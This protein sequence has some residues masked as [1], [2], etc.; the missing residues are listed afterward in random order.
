MK[1]IY[2]I[3]DQETIIQQ[4]GVQVLDTLNGN[5]QYLDRVREGMRQCVSSGFCGY[6]LNSLNKDIAAKTGTAEVGMASEQLTNSL[7][8]G[9]AP[10]DNPK[11]AFVCVAPNSY[12]GVTQANITQEIAYEILS[13]YFKT[14]E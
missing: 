10:A 7:I 3:N 6:Q 8:V 12:R 14:Y 13:E 5:E 1:Q 9:Y 4:Y 11:I 2:E